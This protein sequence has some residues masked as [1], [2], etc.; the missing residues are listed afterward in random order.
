MRALAIASV[1]IALGQPANPLTGAWTAEYRGTTYVRVA[2]ADGT[3]EPQG[4]MSIGQSIHVD[5]DG[6][7]DS[8]TPASPTL[9]RMLDVRWN[10]GTLS[11]TVKSGDDVDR[12]ELRLVDANH[13]ELIPIFSEQ[14]RQQLAAERIPDP[15]PFRLTRA[16]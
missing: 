11:F 1:A 2:L 10:D 12:F 13:A 8:A 6:N 4:A 3:A 14:E 16:R 7:V 9:G 5:D 15:K